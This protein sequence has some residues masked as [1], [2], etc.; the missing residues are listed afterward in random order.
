MGNKLAA[1]A[2]I[3]RLQRRTSAPPLARFA[4]MPERNM[5][6]VHA[7]ATGCYG[8][9]EIAQP[10]EIHYA[11]VG[12]IV[13]MTDNFWELGDL[14]PLRT[15]LR[16]DP[17]A[18]PFSAASFMTKGAVLEAAALHHTGPLALVELQNA[19][20]ERMYVAGT[21]NFYAITRYNWS[22]YYA[23]AVIELGQKVARVVNR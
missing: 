16:P 6:I 1:D 2:E 3:P 20:A 13:K 8:M 5:A 19:G 11:T 9:T 22:S 12:R 7:Y 21:D 4:A 23:M 18:T 10:F 15:P 17:V 14:T